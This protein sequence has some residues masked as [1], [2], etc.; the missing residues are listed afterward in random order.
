MKLICQ[1]L[2]TTIAPQLHPRVDQEQGSGEINGAELRIVAMFANCAQYQVV[3]LT[4]S[5]TILLLLYIGFCVLHP[6]I[7]QQN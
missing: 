6:L 3:F 4:P 7:R 5:T 2:H 1:I